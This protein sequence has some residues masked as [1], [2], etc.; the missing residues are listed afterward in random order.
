MQEAG[1][2]GR[3]VCR[4]QVARDMQEVHAFMRKSRCQKRA[5]GGG[6]G[7]VYRRCLIVP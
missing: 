2:G 6:A 5:E 7:G 3:S 1:G 4:M